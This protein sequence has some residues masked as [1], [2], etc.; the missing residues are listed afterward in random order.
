VIVSHAGIA[1]SVARAGSRGSIPTGGTVY[2]RIA[3]D[4]SDPASGAE[5]PETLRYR[6]LPEVSSVTLAP[7]ESLYRD[8]P[9]RGTNGEDLSVRGPLIMATWWTVAEGG[10]EEFDEWYE[11]EHIPTLFRVPGWLR[12]RRFELVSGDGPTHFAIHDLTDARVFGHPTQRAAATTD[13]RAR[14]VHLRTLFDRR[15]YALDSATS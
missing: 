14:V 11:Q 15:I 13:W 5:A 4:G 9:L 2:R 6:D 10:L 12:I 3:D 7:T 1:L 8:R